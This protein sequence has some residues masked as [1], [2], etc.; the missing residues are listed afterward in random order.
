MLPRAA[1]ESEEEL[2]SDSLFPG[3]AMENE[4]D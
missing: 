4:K 2:G 3:D 1:R